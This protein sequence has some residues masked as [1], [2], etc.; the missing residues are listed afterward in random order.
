MLVMT[1]KIFALK[2]DEDS[3]ATIIALAVVVVVERNIMLQLAL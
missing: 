2:L 1:F 3:R